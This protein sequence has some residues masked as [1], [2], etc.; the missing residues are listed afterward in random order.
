MLIMAIA[1]DFVGLW[2][3]MKVVKIKV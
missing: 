2:V 3:I 1:L